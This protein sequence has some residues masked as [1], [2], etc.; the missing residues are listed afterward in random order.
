MPMGITSENVAAQYGYT[1]EQQDEYAQVE[2]CLDIMYSSGFSLQVRQCLPRQSQS[3]ARCRLL[4]RRDR[5]DESSVG[6]AC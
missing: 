6:D 1:R 4:G 3:G 5:A 2:L